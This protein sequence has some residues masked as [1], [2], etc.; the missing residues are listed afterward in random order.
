MIICLGQRRK[1]R[2][3]PRGAYGVVTRSN[4]NPDPRP[5]L[6]IQ[7]ATGVGPAMRHQHGCRGGIEHRDIFV[8]FPPHDA[9][10]LAMRA[11]GR[12]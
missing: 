1:M 4:L 6:H 3:L 11:S 12:P 7:R 2:P 5:A 10:P 8:A 9:L